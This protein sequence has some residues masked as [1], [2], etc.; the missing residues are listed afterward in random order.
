MFFPN[1]KPYLLQTVDHFGRVKH[2]NWTRQFKAIRNAIGIQF[3]A[4]IIHESCQWSEVHKLW[5]F[6]P[7]KVS[8]EKY[9]SNTDDYKG[10][11]YLITADETFE[12]TNYVQINTTEIHTT[13]GFSAFQFLPSSN[14][15]IIV[16]IKS[17]ELEGQPFSSYYM[18]FDINGIVYVG[19]TKMPGNFK[20]EG[21]EFVD[22]TKD[23]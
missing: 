22:W 5:F 23:F 20:L 7:R 15:T 18:V 10:S 6:L 4:Y 9:D 21:L 19:E 13:H 11:N 16:A 12:K 3:P 8:F 14:D 17:K 1:F 2:L